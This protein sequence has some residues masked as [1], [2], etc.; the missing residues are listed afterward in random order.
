[1]KA[2]LTLDGSPTSESILPTAQRL[3]D[4]VPTL[5]LHILRVLDPKDAQGTRA[6]PIDNP[7]G[8]AL[9]SITVPNPQPPL[10]ESHGD[11]EARMSQETVS[12]LEA[13]TR[14]WFAGCEPTFH[15]EWSREPARAICEYAERIKAD[16]IVMATHGRSGLSHVVAGSVAEAVIRSSGRPVL[17]QCPGRD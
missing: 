9:G 15:V 8:R 16:V 1:M 10:V 2:L 12:S 3:L 4:L 11:A 5:E 6:R 7:Q 14:G 17:I 13:L